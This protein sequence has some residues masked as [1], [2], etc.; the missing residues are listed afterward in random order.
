MANL[1]PSVIGLDK[2][3]N[4]QTAKLVAPAGSVLDTLNYE[5]VDFQG[6]KRID[7][8]ARY[9]GSLLP[10]LDEYYVITLTDTFAGAVGNLVATDEGLLGVVV[11]NTTTT[12]YVAVIN[13]NV[14]PA[15]GDTLYTV[16][17]GV[18][19]DGNVVTAV[20]TGVDAAANADV[21]YDN[22][23]AF[24]EAL[25]N[26]IEELP[27]PI[28]GLHWFRDRLY[29]VA[30]TTAVSLSGTTPIIYPN[31]V[32]TLAGTDYN[33]LDSFVLDNT[34]LVFLDALNPADWQVEGAAVTRDGVSVGTVANGFE[35]LTT[36]IATFFES[37]S[38]AQ[39]LEE[40][41]PSGPYDFGWRFVHQ[42]WE[43]LFESGLSLYGSLPSLNQNIIGLG[44]QGPT[45]ITGNSGKPLLLVQKIAVAGKPTQVNGWKSS[46]NA[47]SYDL[48]A[49]NVAEDDS[50]YVYADAY[51]SWSAGSSTLQAPGL[52]TAT[53]TEYPADNTVVVEIT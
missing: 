8:F 3:L 24:T 19:V 51:V 20:S 40:D 43:V 2:G 21:H 4:L 52:T 10:A 12:L 46:D 30:S 27:G 41:G 36:E 22:L 50:L 16:E 32:L 29:A 1:V 15:V 5:Q 35:D 53:L 7:G 49:G 14:I 34:R 18:N 11:G 44:T 48:D 9:D 25:R 6:Q 33:V 28:A 17:D 31:D 47:E 26:R 39:V 45:P 38:E 37:R 42:G 23:L 13:S